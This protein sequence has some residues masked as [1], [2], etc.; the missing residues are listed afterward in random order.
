MA[1]F[2]HDPSEATLLAAID[3][4]WR[5]SMRAFGQA[6]H[7][8][9][10][11]DD[12]VFWFITGVPDSA[13]N[14]I[15]YARLTPDQIAPAVLEL[16]TLRST[17]TVP[18]NWLV[19]PDSRPT[20]L[21][22]HLVTCGLQHFIDLP[23]MTVKLDRLHSDR[24]PPANLTIEVVESDPVWAE[25]IIAE[26]R[27]YEV[28][29]TLGSSLTTLRTGMGASSHHL[30]F[31]HYLGRLDGHPVATASLLLSEGIAGIYDV[32]TVP[33]ARKRGVGTAMMLHI[34]HMAQQQ[35]Y[36]HAWLQPSEMAY[37]FYERLGFQV[38]GVCSIYG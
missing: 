20:D 18:M 12:H 11:D 23:W 25:W 9:L 5:A 33:S 28:D 19:G 27:G 14:S 21:G 6:P 1:A 16:Q 22:L 32:T 31:Y 2:L 36:H 30:R 38:C 35:G 26:Q 15:M 3:R 29:S 8:H 10:R 4:N 37:P 34:L 13:F 7:V 24:L 17:H